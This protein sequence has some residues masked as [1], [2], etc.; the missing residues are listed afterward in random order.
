MRTIVRLDKVAGSAHPKDILE[1]AWEA[2]LDRDYAPVF[3]PALAV[4]SVLPDGKPVGNAIRTVAECANRV[5]D[6]L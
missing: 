5:A 4:L 3:R 1:A 6:S 2:I